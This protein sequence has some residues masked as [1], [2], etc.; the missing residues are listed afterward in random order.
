MIH[1]L[2]NRLQHW[3]PGVRD[4]KHT[5]T[6]LAR[7]Y[8]SEHLYHDMTAG[9]DKIEHPQVRLFFE[10]IRPT[11][12]CV[13][14]G[15]GGGVVFAAAAARARK[16]VGIDIAVLALRKALLRLREKTYSKL[17]IQADVAGAP[18]RDGCADVSYSFEVL[19]H[20]WDP[21][22]VLLEM[23]RV[24]R[25]GGLIFF[26]TPNQFSLNL[27][28]HQRFP[29]RCVEYLLAML[30]WLRSFFSTRS[31]R[32]IQPDLCAIPPYP[33]CDMIASFFPRN[34]R[35]FLQH[36][37]CEVLRLETFFFQQAKAANE[38][39]R[40]RYESYDQS[41]FYRNFGDHILCVARKCE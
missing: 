31:Y 30:V 1:Q 39:L 28:L 27:Q 13:E 8:A 14:F 38:K 18:L 25:P 4:R 26:T 24:T 21:E 40:W 19:E 11:D 5:A 35:N 7:F 10:Q 32:N 20:V 23:I 6:A 37:G 41:V 15:C 17:I 12:V 33:D 3:F 36:H 2:I 9:A 16:I 29:V 22:A 34:L